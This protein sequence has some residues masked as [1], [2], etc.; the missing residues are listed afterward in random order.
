MKAKSDDGDAVMVLSLVSV[1]TTLGS[2]RWHSQPLRTHDSTSSR[3]FN[4]LASLGN[5][6][7]RCFIV[8]VT[9]NALENSRSLSARLGTMIQASRI[10]RLQL[11]GTK[12]LFLRSD[13]SHARLLRLPH[14]RR[15]ELA[16]Y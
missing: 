8:E 13:S 2:R 9:S 6:A 4:E 15:I 3:V 11:T 1:E 7:S 14:K 10:P 5:L 16:S 12:I